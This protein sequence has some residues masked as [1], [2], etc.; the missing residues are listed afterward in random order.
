MKKYCIYKHTTPN[1]KVYIGLTSLN[2]IYRWDN[3]RGYKACTY[4]YNAILKY[5]WD[6][7]RHEILFTDL[8]KQQAELKE[9]ELISQYKQLGLSYNIKSG[10]KVNDGYIGY[11]HSEDTRKKISKGGIGIKF[12]KQQLENMSKSHKGNKLSE[13]AKSKISKS[14]IQMDLDGNFIA[15]WKSI[16]EAARILGFKS[17]SKISECCYN[18]RVLRGKVISKPTAYGFKWGFEDGLNS[19]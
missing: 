12:S 14:V 13:E 2:P 7:I 4:F 18:K 5:G 11:K 15:R 16:A 10:G 8:T 3:G 17:P 9:I 6:N 1:Q 19:I